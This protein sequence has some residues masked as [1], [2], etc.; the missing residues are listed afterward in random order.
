MNNKTTGGKWGW[1]KEYMQKNDISQGDVANAL[2][3]QKTRVSELL[4]GK[5]DFPVNKVFPA[6]RFFNLD[7]EELTKYNSGFTQQIPSTD[8]KKPLHPAENDLVDIEIVRPSVAGKDAFF[9]NI[10]RQ[11]ISRP[12]FNL[13]AVSSP[14]NVKAMIAKGDSM[15]PTISDGDMVWADISVKEPTADGLYLFAIKDEV[16][17]KRL[18]LDNFNHTALIISDNALY[19]PI[20]ISRPDHLTTIGKITSVTK[21]YR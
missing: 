5:R 11:L 8:G 3:W 10:G 19:P 4:C 12:I 6:A 20:S 18:Q 1:L 2:H 17:I 13:L 15:Q 14:A 9:E 7:L 21:I 16:F